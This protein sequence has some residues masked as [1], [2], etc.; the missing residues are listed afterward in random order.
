MLEMQMEI[1]ILREEIKVIKKDPGI[2]R[3]NLNNREKATI[4]DALKNRYSLS[5]LLSILH[6]SRSSYYY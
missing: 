3:K 4:V 5:Q 1:D 6:L 2:N